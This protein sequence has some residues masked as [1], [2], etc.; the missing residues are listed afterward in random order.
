MKPRQKKTRDEALVAR[1]RKMFSKVPGVEEK[2]MFGS[3][4]FMVRAKMCVSAR[5]ERIMCRLDPA[6]HDQ[7]I[8][9]PGVRTVAMSGRKYRGYVHVAA[10][11]LQSE[12]ALKSWIGLALAYNKR[13]RM[14]PD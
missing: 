10:E 5:A 12:R 6:I 3:V 7:A 8:E 11:A 13:L 9:L 14:T 1:V 4:A 2:K